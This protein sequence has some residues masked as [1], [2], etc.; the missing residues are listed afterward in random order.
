MSVLGRFAGISHRIHSIAI[1]IW[2][3]LPNGCA[4]SRWTAAQHVALPRQRYVTCKSRICRTTSSN[5]AATT[6]RDAWAMATVRRRALAPAPWC[7][8]RAISWRKYRVAFRPRHLN[9]IWSPMRLSRF[10]M[11]ASDIYVRWPDCEYSSA[12]ITC[13]M[14]QSL[15]V[16]SLSLCSDLSNNQITILSNYTFANLTKLSTL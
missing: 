2:P 12:L 6:T 9:C 8:V 10:T 13:H 16:F 4:K 14:W 1:V 11:S 3:G 5:A 15:I 7:V